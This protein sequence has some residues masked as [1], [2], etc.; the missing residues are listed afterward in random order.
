MSNF[1]LNFRNLHITA[2]VNFK[3]FYPDGRIHWSTVPLQNFV[4]ENQ[5]RN[6]KAEN[7][8]ITLSDSGDCFFITCTDPETTLNIKISRTAPG[9]KIGKDGRTN[10]GQDPKD[11]WGF[12]RHIFWPTAKAEGTVTIKGENLNIAGRACL[13]MALQGMKPHHAG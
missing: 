8:K 9:F 5:K 6:L 12:I 11:P 7:F 2:Q 4:F 1:P 3:M 13:S 10:F